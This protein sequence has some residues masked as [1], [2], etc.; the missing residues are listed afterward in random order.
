MLKRLFLLLI[1]VDVILIIGAVI[2]FLTRPPDYF[3]WLDDPTL[4]GSCE[5][6]SI[7]ERVNATRIE[8]AQG[9]ITPDEAVTG[10]QA[11]LS[12]HVPELDLSSVRFSR[13]LLIETDTATGARSPAYFI[14]AA[15]VPIDSGSEMLAA[16]AVFV[17][18]HVNGG[19]FHF[20]MSANV[21]SP[22]ETCLND[23]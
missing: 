2:F 8:T 4:T 20:V 7:L 5:A 12:V 14:T 16:T 15:W 9:S 18:N 10:A 22:A 21:Q 19:I 11:I 6:A 1:P 23:R 17:L 13:P 3:S